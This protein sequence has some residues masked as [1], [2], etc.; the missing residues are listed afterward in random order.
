MANL[1]IKLLREHRS[2]NGR[3]VFDYA[4]SGSPEDLAKYKAIQ[5]VNYREDTATGVP[6]YFTTRF[7]GATG[8]L[9]ITQ[10]NKIV[11]DMSAYD[12]AASI[13]SQYGGNFGQEL[14]RIAAERLLNVRTAVAPREAAAPA[15]TSQPAEEPATSEK[16][17]LG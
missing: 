2:K 16:E 17:D 10:N 1:K 6:M 5:G 7:V 13:A 3:V 11:P 15:A 8:Q 12:E 4:V 9:I 14:A